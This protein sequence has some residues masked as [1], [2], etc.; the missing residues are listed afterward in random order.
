LSTH[1]LIKLLFRQQ[2]PRKSTRLAFA[3]GSTSPIAT[4]GT[5]ASLA[6]ACTS[7]VLWPPSA[8]WTTMPVLPSQ[9][10]PSGG[11][12]AVGAAWPV[13]D[14]SLA[15]SKFK[16]T[17]LDGAAA[18]TTPDGPTAVASVRDCGNAVDSGSRRSGSR[19]PSPRSAAV[20]YCVAC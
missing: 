10:L 8:V 12:G 3:C 19:R 4:S 11:I 13:Q 20:A 1:A 5:V 6:F 7:S 9:P 17:R 15:A 2:A 14:P 16:A 18:L